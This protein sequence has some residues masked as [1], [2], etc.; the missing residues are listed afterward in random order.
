MY[1]Y[2][3]VDTKGHLI[4]RNT[5][6]NLIQNESYLALKKKYPNIVL[7]SFLYWT[8]VNE[9]LFPKSHF[10]PGNEQQLQTVGV[11][12][13]AYEFDQHGGYI[14]SGLLKVTPVP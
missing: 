7:T 6:L 14:D 8:K 12:D 3:I 9:D 13:V 1:I 2:Y 11:A 5:D 10:L 4:T